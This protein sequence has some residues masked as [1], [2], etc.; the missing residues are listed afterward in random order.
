VGKKVMTSPFAVMTSSWMLQITGYAPM[1]ER[2][3]AAD[4]GALDS[5]TSK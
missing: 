3:T 1:P 2:L 4:V 5:V